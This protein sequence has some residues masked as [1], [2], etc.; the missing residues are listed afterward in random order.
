[1][2]SEPQNIASLFVHVPF[3]VSEKIQDLGRKLENTSTLQ[4]VFNEPWRS[5]VD[6][7]INTID[8]LPAK[9]AKRY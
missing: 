2:V 9:L 1:M 6:P 4:A 8:K 5:L 7:E 3:A